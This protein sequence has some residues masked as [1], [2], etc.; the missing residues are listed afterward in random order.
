MQ[1]T[2]LSSTV[3]DAAQR[4]DV[5]RAVAELHQE[6]AAEIAKRRPLCVL[7]G[8][9]CRFEEYGHRLYITTLELAAFTAAH[10]ERPAP[11]IPQPPWDGTGC[12][13]QLNKL[14]GVHDIRPFG[15]RMFFCDSTATQWQQD[16]YEKFHAQLKSLHETLL[17]PY[18]YVEWRSALTQL[19]LA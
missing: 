19:G 8:K 13:F 7:S 5:R 2:S 10:A 12:P 3:S 9:C 6:V 16:Q 1:P 15:C 4:P 14:C 18:A 11:V 17:V